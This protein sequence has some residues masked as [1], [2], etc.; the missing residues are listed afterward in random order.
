MD[1]NVCLQLYLSQ[2]RQARKKNQIFTLGVLCALAR[3][4]SGRVRRAHRELDRT[5]VYGAHDAPY[6]SPII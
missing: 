6:A 3:L 4:N 2:R 1:A 5:T